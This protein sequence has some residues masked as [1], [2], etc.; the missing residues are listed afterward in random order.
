MQITDIH[1]RPAIMTGSLSKEKES[2]LKYPF[3]EKILT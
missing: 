1:E 3:P 2:D